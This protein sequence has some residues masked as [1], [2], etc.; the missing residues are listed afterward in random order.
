MKYI[1]LVIVILL[2]LGFLTYYQINGVKPSGEIPTDTFKQLV[3]VCQSGGGHQI[4]W[5]E[6][7][8][9]GNECAI[10]TCQK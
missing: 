3:T 10:L 9:G 7:S 1:P 5:I 2:W 8:C 4:A 6:A